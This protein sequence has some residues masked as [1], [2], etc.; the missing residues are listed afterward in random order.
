MD[1]TP[2]SQPPSRP[3]VHDTAG[4]SAQCRAVL[5]AAMRPL[6]VLPLVAMGFLFVYGRLVCPFMDRTDPLRLLEGLAMI[7]VWQI[8]L[9]EA[10]MHWSSPPRDGAVARHGYR[11]AVLSWGIAGL[12]AVVLHH[13]R[14][15]DFHLS[16]HLKLLLGY[17]VLG[18]GILAQFEYSM[19]ER[20]LRQ[21][22]SLLAQARSVRDRLG[23]RLM[24]SFLAF[25]VAPALSMVLMVVRYQLEG[26]VIAG[27]A[28]EVAFI[29][30]VFM[31]SG[32]F[33]AWH[34]GRMLREDADAIVAGLE[35]ISA[36]NLDV[37]LSVPRP[38]EIGQVAIGI[39]DMVAGLRQRDLIRDAFGR[40]VSPKV[41]QRVLKDWAIETVPPVP[42]RSGG[43][44]AARG[45]TLGG[46]H[47]DVTV[48][49]VD[50]RGFTPL[51]ER[52]EPV[53]LTDLL[54]GWFCRAVTAVDEH[55]GVVDKF[56]GDAVMAVFGIEEN[57]Q[58]HA[59]RAVQCAKAL[60]ET[61]QAYNAE[62]VGEPPLKIGIGIHSGPVVAGTVG[63]PHRM[64]FTVIGATV[65]VAS[66][67]EAA[68]R[69][70]LP[71]ILFSQETARR[72]AVHQPSHEVARLPLKGV[73][74]PVVLY[75]LGDEPD[76]PS[77]SASG[78]ASDR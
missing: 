38:D 3:P 76:G 24:E 74:D 8:V 31:I 14:Y 30:L 16:S 2:A 25:T 11:M 48:V 70:P 54:N 33:V 60:E 64:E 39:N 46:Q 32:V 18:G 50:L 22:G 6:H 9:R 57:D 59:L 26:Y 68:A 10:L 63:S 34:Y 71:S 55:G 61:M 52:L 65:N 40:F 20:K 19:L 28:M 77:D 5:I 43:A 62:R 44:D 1:I 49:M 72:I 15:P 75:A 29:V 4:D 17:W 12:S 56:I 51:S 13:F 58:T 35:R 27:V 7:A 47:R 67:I 42:A 45:I 23:R 69:A 73:Q 36:G 21:R 66:R 41:V 37:H 53:Q 78:D